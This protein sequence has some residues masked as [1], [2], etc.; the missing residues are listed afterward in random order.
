MLIEC[1]KPGEMKSLYDYLI[2]SDEQIDFEIG[3][4]MGTPV[5][6]QSVQSFMMRGVDNLEIARAAIGAYEQES[7]YGRTRDEIIAN[8]KKHFSSCTPCMRQY[9][10]IVHKQAVATAQGIKGLMT[11]GA[12][13]QANKGLERYIRQGDV[14][15]IL[16]EGANPPSNK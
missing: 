11:K 2:T 15:G 14:L 3:V 7:T 12:I 10:V 9:S 13:P 6:D 5:M 8:S 16:H 1:L 4:T